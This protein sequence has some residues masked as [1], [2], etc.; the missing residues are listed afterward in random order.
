VVV[1]S[2]FTF[3]SATIEEDILDVMEPVVVHPRFHG[4]QSTPASSEGKRRKRSI[5]STDQTNIIDTI[6]SLRSSVGASDMNYLTYSSHYENSAGNWTSHCN[7][8]SDIYGDTTYAFGVKYATSSPIDHV[9]ALQLSFNT[10]IFYNRL[11]S[12]HLR[13]VG[14]GYTYCSLLRAQGQYYWNAYLAIYEFSYT[15]DFNERVAQYTLGEACTT[16][17]SG[18][19]WCYQGLCKDDCSASDSNCYCKSSCPNTAG[20]DTATCRCRCLNG[21]TGSRCETRECISTQQQSCSTT[22]RV[23]KTW[24]MGSENNEASILKS[25]ALL[26]LYAIMALFLMQ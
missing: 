17:L 15:S 9:K 26:C 3:T 1:V 18:S 8:D 16:C 12:V 7:F 20:T 4:E 14:A 5:S 25:M 2:V 13:Y 6:N 24:N 19:Y 10:S 11:R 23:Q 22:P 21:W